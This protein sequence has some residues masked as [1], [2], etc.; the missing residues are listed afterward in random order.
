MPSH[1]GTET[2]FELTTIERLEGQG[3]THLLGLELDRPHDE[4]VLRDVLRGNL[5]GRYPTLSVA[6]L[7]EAVARIARPEG[8]DTL[9]RN[10]AF[11]RL[12]TKG[13][14]LPVEYPDGRREVVHVWPIDWQRPGA[15]AFHVVNQLPVHGRNDR[16]P[17]VLIYV[18]GLPLALFELKNP[19]SPAPTVEEAWN[20]IQ[21]YTHEV[22]QLFDYNTLCVVS[23]GVHTHH[24]MWTAG[25][26]WYAAWKSIDGQA[27]EPGTT[28]SMK[29]LVQGLFPPD[30]L[31]Q[32][33]RDF[34]LFEVANEKITKKGA[35]YHQFFAVLVAA[36]RALAAACPG[37]DRRV[38]VVWHTTGSG[39]SLTMAFLV[40][41]LRRASA[42]MN[43]TFV[44]QV[45]RTDL[46]ISSTTSSLP[47]GILWGTCSTPRASTG[48]VNCSGRRAA[49]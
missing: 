13:L 40:G 23:D 43:P 30:R 14:E 31:L 10:R 27:V 29:T 24:G 21:H 1:R 45:D 12:L 44:I 25:L 46:T 36:E 17:D 42:L 16:R 41:V 2:D 39:K 19:W 28:A 5:A 34:V 48:C 47:P 22:P 37:A 9:H 32:Y 38:G 49:K 20:Q 11:Q 8:V 6:A 33:V 7:D 4:V 26:E 15:T 3:Y 18:N 35:K